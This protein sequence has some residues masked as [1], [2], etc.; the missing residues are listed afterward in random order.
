MHPNFYCSPV[1]VFV[2]WLSGYVPCLH[3][4]GYPF[5]FPF[6]RHIRSYQPRCFLCR[7]SQEYVTFVPGQ[8]GPSGPLLLY[9]LSPFSGLGREGQDPK[10]ICR[11]IYVTHSQSVDGRAEPA[12][13][14]V[15]GEARWFELWPA[16]AR[17]SLR[18]L[19][20]G[21]QEQIIMSV[22]AICPHSNRNKE[23]S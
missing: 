13:L 20:G 8:N 7:Q 10:M 21:A 14:A 5:H 4:K 23:S 16:F 2:L 17:L 19:S 9:S 22:A 3:S 18:Y 15:F 1:N 6:V 12:I 11:Y